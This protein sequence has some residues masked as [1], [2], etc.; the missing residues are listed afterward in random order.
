MIYRWCF[1][2]CISWCLSWCL[3]CADGRYC[4]SCR[5]YTGDVSVDACYVQM[6]VTTC[7]VDDIQVMY[8]VCIRWCISWCL[9]CADGCYYLSCRW[10]TGDESG[11]VSVDACCVQT[12]V[13]TSS[14]RWR[15]A[16]MAEEPA[17]CDHHKSGVT[18]N[19]WLSRWGIS[20]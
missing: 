16:T 12:A 15:P 11:D 19:T 5:W 9:L 13:T 10:Y 17:I 18:V 8:Q 14:W 20:S 1:R 3:L 2:C 7:H 4:L 6:V